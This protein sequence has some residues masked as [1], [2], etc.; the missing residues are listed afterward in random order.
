MSHDMWDAKAYATGA[1]P[2][3]FSLPDY[4][5]SLLDTEFLESSSTRDTSIRHQLLRAA[6]T[7]I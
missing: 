2:F 1:L 6:S 7:S 3:M 4:L 5:M